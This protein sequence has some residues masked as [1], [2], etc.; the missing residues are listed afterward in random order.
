MKILVLNGPNLDCLGTREPGIYGN[1][2]LQDI[3]EKLRCFGKANDIELLFKQTAFEGEL[4]NILNSSNGIY[5]GIIFNPAAYTHYSV[6][7]Y[8]AIRCTRVPVV[9]VHLSN[10][11]AR[12]S[13][14]A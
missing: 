10:V 12:E 7:I 13:F 14:R 2:T 11:F 5:D 4:V 3:E 8:D 6:A 9:E 1:E